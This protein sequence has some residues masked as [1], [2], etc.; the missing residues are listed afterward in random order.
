MYFRHF[1]F[2]ET[3]YQFGVCS[4]NKD[5]RTFCCL[6]YFQNVNFHAVHEVV[7][8][9]GDLFICSQNCIDLAHLNDYIFTFF[10]LNDGCYYFTFFCDVLIEQNFSFCFTEFLNNNLF[11][12]LCRNSA[13]VF[14]CYF[15]IYDII[16]SIAGVQYSCHFQ[17]NFQLRIFYCFHNCFLC[18]AFYFT[19]FSVHIYFDI[20]ACAKMLF[21]CRNQRCFDRFENDFL[22]DPFFLCNQFQCG[23]K[24]FAIHFPDSSL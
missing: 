9:A 8:F 11:C 22:I 16:H 3:F 13:E 14:R 18:K 7:L 15:D 23:Q 21:A 24:F 17:R 4:G 6:F 1:L 5:L 2:E 12:C 20:L 19:S 10:S